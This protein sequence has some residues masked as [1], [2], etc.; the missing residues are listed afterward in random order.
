[1]LTNC[2]VP[3]LLIYF[4]ILTKSY[5]KL[6]SWESPP[7]FPVAPPG[8]SRADRVRPN[9]FGLVSSGPPPHGRPLLRWQ[10]RWE[11]PR[12]HSWCRTP[13]TRDGLI[14]PSNVANFTTLCFSFTFRECSSDALRRGSQRWSHL[15]ADAGQ[16]LWEGDLDFFGFCKTSL[17]QMLIV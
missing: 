10:H 9:Q 3:L 1:M 7:R 15:S 5:T 4:E 11:F 12:G 6:A 17:H 16:F 14:L 2:T 8:F 13:S